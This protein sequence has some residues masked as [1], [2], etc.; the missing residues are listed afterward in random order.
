MSSRL[1][2]KIWGYRILI[3]CLLLSMLVA[4]C[5]GSSEPAVEDET[6]SEETVELTITTWTGNES[7]LAMFN[8]I[9]EAYKVDHPNVGVTFTTIPF[10][11]YVS[12]V[13]IQLAGSNPPDAGW[14]VDSTAPTFVNAGVLKDLRPTLEEF[15]EYDLADFAEGPM[16]L[17]V[18]DDA[19][20]GV[21]FSTSP[22]II[23]YNRDLFAEAGMETPDVLIEK[24]EWTWDALRVAAK[25]IAEATPDT[26]YGFESYGGGIYGARLWNTMGPLM[27]A[28]GGE[29]WD[30]AGKL[31]T[32]NSPEAVAAFKF[33]H[34][35]TFEDE[36]AVPPGEVADFFAGNAGMTIAQLGRTAVLADAAFEWGIAPLP[37]GPAG[38]NPTVGQAAFVVFNAGRNV[39]IAADFVA[40][41]TTKTNVTKMSTYFPPARKS[42]INSEDFLNSNPLVSPESMAL[43][44]VPS[45]ESGTVEVVHENYPKIDLAARGVLDQFWVLG[46]NAQKILDDT[47]EAIQPYMLP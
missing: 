22:Y 37:S 45:I 2:H 12:K 5:S 35:M 15:P 23:Y 8:E 16:N 17:W 19:I 6:T 36:S 21:P 28:Y 18:K 7:Q 26:V 44:I 1:L 14:I 33:I 20:Y 3:I 46:A 13:T 11:D 34:E 40:F 39:D 24:G 32:I 29:A 10:E 47:C 25:A 31:C 27:K 42:I 43:A 38:Y 4:S 41:L 30:A 9:A